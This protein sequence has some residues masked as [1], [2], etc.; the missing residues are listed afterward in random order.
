MPKSRDQRCQR[1]LHEFFREKTQ[2]L[3]YI[4][5]KENVRGWKYARYIVTIPDKW[6]VS[7]AHY[8]AQTRSLVWTNNEKTQNISPLKNKI[9]ET[10]NDFKTKF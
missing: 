4:L 3:H 10:K 6:T 7:T 5:K 8:D 9:E 2:G 1:I